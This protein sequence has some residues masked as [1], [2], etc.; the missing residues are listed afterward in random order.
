MIILIQLIKQINQKNQI[1]LLNPAR[2]AM[3]LFNYRLP[4]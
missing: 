3:F 1:N 2:S 4:G